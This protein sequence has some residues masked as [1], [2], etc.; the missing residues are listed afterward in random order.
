M[1]YLKLLSVLLW[2]IIFTAQE[3]NAQSVKSGISDTKDFTSIVQISG[4]ADT[5]DIKLKDPYSNQYVTYK[6]GTFYGTLDGNS[7]KFYCI[8]MQ[9]NL[10][11]N[12]DYW[13]N[14]PTPSEITYILNNYFP[15]QNHPDA[16]WSDR[17]EAAAVQVAIWHFSD[18]LDANTVTNN[19][20]VKNR[21]LEIIADANANHASNPSMETL[22]LIP[23][24]QTVFEGDNAVLTVGAYNLNGDG[25]E[26]VTV[27]LTSTG[28]SIAPTSVTTDA[29]GHAGPITVSLNGVG[30]VTVTAE[31]DVVIPQGTRYIH[32]NYPNSKQKLVL[33]TPIVDKKSVTATIEW[34]PKKEDCDLNG[35][36]TFTIGGWSSPSNSGPG[37]IRDMF[38]DDVF[39]GDLTIGGTYTITLTSADAVRTF[40]QNSG[41]TPG[42]LDQSYVDP[43]GSTS[44]GNLADQLVAATLNVEF[45]RAGKT[46]SNTTDLAD[47]VF[48]SGDFA[49]MTVDAVLAIA[50][51]AIGG[52]ST[53]GYSYSEINDAL[54]MI[55]ENFVDG[56]ANEGY[57]DCGYEECENT[58]GDFVW[59]D[60]NVNGTQD[61]GETGIPGVVVELYSGSSLIGTTVTDNSGYYEFTNVVN[62]T[63]TVKIADVNFIDGAVLQNNDN[64]STIWF[65]TK[66]DQGDDSEDSDGHLTEHTASVTIECNDDP[67]IDFGFFK[68]CVDLQKSGPGSVNLGETVTYNFVITNCG[69]VLLSGGAKLYDPLLGIDGQYFAIPV[70]QQAEFSFEYTP[71][72]D[73]CGELINDAYV[74]GSPSLG[75]Y[76]FGGKTVKAEDSHSVIVICDTPCEGDGIIGDKVWLDYTIDLAE[77]NCNGI[78]DENEPGIE[79][80]KVILKDS[81]G[82]A[83]AFD[84][85]DENGNYLFENLCVDNSCYSVHIDMSTLPEGLNTAPVNAGSDDAVDSDENG[86][87]VC[88]TE[89]NQTNLTIDFGFCQDECI[90][91]E[92]GC[93]GDFVWFDENRNG[94]QDNNEVGISDVK[95]QLFNQNG[96]KMGEQ[97]TDS[98]GYYKFEDLLPGRY[99]V[100]FTA[101]EGY[102]YT[103]QNQGS[104]DELDS[105]VGID[106]KTPITLFVAGYCDLSWDA[107]FIPGPGCIGDRVWFDKNHN[108][109]QDLNELGIQ[110]VTVHLINP[111]NNDVLATT[112]TNA[113]GYYKF[114]NL[115][116]GTYQVQFEIP[117]DYQVTLRDQGNDD[118]LDSDAGSNGLTDVISL[119]AG[120]CQIK[121]DAGLFAELPDLRLNKVVDNPNPEVG[122][123][124]K[125]TITI[126]NDG[127]AD[128]T[129]IEVTDYFPEEGLTYTSFALTSGSFT[130]S[131]NEGIW[132]ISTL[133]AGTSEDL[134]L[135]FVVDE[136]NVTNNFD[137]FDL[138]PASDYNVFA[139]CSVNFPSSDT[140]CKVAVGWDAYF[141]Y[142]SIG[143]KL[144]VSDGTQDVLVV[145]RSLTFVSGAVYNGNVVYGTTTNLPQS[146]VTITNG[147]LIQDPNRID[148]EAAGTYL[149]NLSSQLASY[150][151]NGTTNYQWGGLYLEGSD[152]FLNVFHVSGSELTSAH[153]LS[154]S[155]PNG[156]V[157]VVNVDGDNI[158]WTG[159]LIV[160]GTS[161]NNVLYNFYQA[162]M[163]TIVGI[164][165]RGS[166]LAPCA[167]V[168]FQSGV[169][170]GQMIAKY[171]T[172]IGQYNCEPFLGNIPKRPNI[173]NTAEITAVDQMDPD[174]HPGNGLSSEDDYSAATVYFGNEEAGNGGGNSGDTGDWEEIGS[175]ASTQ[176]IWSIA[177]D[178]DGNLLA[179]TAGGSLYRMDHNS[180]EWVKINE[181][182]LVGFIWNIAVDASDNIYIGT[183]QGIFKTTDGGTTWSGPL[184]SLLY[185]IRALEVDKV[186][187]DIY[188][189]AWGFGVYKSTDGGN[190]WMQKNT[191]L[192]NLIVN[193]ITMD[194]EGRLFAGTFGG[195]I[196]ISED[197]ADTW[198]TSSI[199][200]NLVWTIAVTSQDVVYAA[201][202]GKGVYMST[203]NG[204]SWSQVNT[205]LTAEHVY[206]VAVNAYDEVYVSTWLGGVY[207]LTSVAPKSSGSTP[208]PNSVV[209]SAVGM[210]GYGISSLMVDKNASTLYA[211]S[212]NGVIYKKR[213]DGVTANN[214]EISAV[215]EYNLSQNYPNPFNPATNIEFSVRESGIYTLKIYNVIGQE[216]AELVNGELNPGYHKVEFDASRLSSGV[217]IYKLVG[218]KVNL[219]RKMILMK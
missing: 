13:D 113:S 176:I 61:N 9:N 144:P 217:Y 138:G 38:F 129:G 211:G 101:P 206:S 23:S 1:R 33:A 123:V 191:G 15:F 14:G 143:D 16:V 90:G 142:Y 5:R 118:E 78:Q 175:F 75:G 199:D 42:A 212:S 178:N 39:P 49:G 7:V 179:G 131:G 40:L 164:D 77:T 128:A 141:S 72:E 149:K 63:Y 21:A 165:V 43:T 197:G 183:E 158:E 127:T 159:G 52:G 167:T 219:S 140:E 218:S 62:G 208:S 109:L 117:E 58:I 207:K 137:E 204:L 81:E 24:M 69:D 91:C 105:D 136:F 186:T 187:G 170:H 216:V 19:N 184:G 139:L 57:L 96:Q 82:V 122:D 196:Y 89:E 112:T 71:T 195:G 160:N 53:S 27:S 119:P 60:S 121:W 36:V 115:S 41:G 169:M 126:T 174:S 56:T 2:V 67:T 130:L 12:Q 157:V 29:T 150:Q 106:G 20:T 83:I 34:I 189:A 70:G 45:D 92:Y 192:D 32:K 35:Y 168:D 104:D 97:Y 26:N 145:G 6:A 200:Y 205:G 88:L 68:A 146:N 166:I 151:T 188:A 99:F 124:I 30:V 76:N 190:T 73:Q 198:S 162:T 47:L 185:D 44:A 203:D 134:E 74:I 107:G 50:N 116:G 100:K 46:G 94:I 114:D 214:D 120:E 193:S 3:T 31:A 54:T 64:L 66:K 79:G 87:T 152:P 210:G 173:T 22:I 177:A 84:I 103:L 59:H 93:V 155:V 55:N 182:M 17:D 180:T 215:T 172:G 147:N 111:V 125:F 95:V 161:V 37:Q 194:S 86:V 51:E 135:Y 11:Y 156:S 8:D 171:L 25:I 163:I 148:F 153:T 85:T 201:T 133:S 65:A 28:G 213:E 132:S 181:G 18:G 202:Y 10:A 154:I 80:V 209:W 98:E 102:V 108:G 110:G 48:A 4:T